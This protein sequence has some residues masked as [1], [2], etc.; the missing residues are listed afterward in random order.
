[1]QLSNLGLTD[2]CTVLEHENVRLRTALAETTLQLAETCEELKICT[3]PLFR[4]WRLR[5]LLKRRAAAVRTLKE[6]PPL[7]AAEPPRVETPSS[8]LI[9]V[10]GR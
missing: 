3:L 2:R 6:G 7:R 4:Q 10:P 5:R 9:I 1:M 8:P